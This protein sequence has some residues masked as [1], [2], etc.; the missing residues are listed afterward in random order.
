MAQDGH[1]G[2][3]WLRI[4]DE[5]VG[6]W[7]RSLFT[8]LVDSA[9]SAA[10]GGQ[11]FSPPGTPTPEMGSGHFPSEGFGKAASMIDLLVSLP[12]RSRM[13]VPP[14]THNFFLADAPRCYYATSDKN[15]DDGRYILY[16]G[17][18]GCRDK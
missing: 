11:V 6:Y 18:G 2:H 12:L 1:K 8:S 9:D 16:G 10:W 3:W 17:P 14:D 7:P 4:N 15:D 13:F 5:D